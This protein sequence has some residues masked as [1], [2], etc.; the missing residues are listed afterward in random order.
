[1]RTLG[2]NN[3]NNNSYIS[4]DLKNRLLNVLESSKQLILNSNDEK[5]RSILRSE[6]IE[7][8]EQ[9]EDIEEIEQLINKIKLEIKKLNQLFWTKE[10]VNELQFVVDFYEARIQNM[11]QA[12]IR[13]LAWY[14][15]EGW[16]QFLN[17]ED[18]LQ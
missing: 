17:K 5:N 6:T 8:H 12:T 2:L 16:K 7:K 15:Q 14:Q 18:D 10:E 3:F 9:I 13:N 4:N 11:I 1:M